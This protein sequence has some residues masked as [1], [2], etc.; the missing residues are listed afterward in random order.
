MMITSCPH[1]PS[2]EQ[3]MTGKK[4]V[5]IPA[6]STAEM[7]AAGGDVINDYDLAI[8]RNDVNHR[9]DVCAD[10]IYKTM[11]TACPNSGKVS[12]EQLM[13]AAKAYMTAQYKHSQYDGIIAAL[14]A[15]GLQIEDQSH[16]RMK[17]D[18]ENE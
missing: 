15:I 6:E 17:K 7:C 14:E 12:R 5:I 16:D 4:M 8:D 11:T 1:G 2:G 10:H 3:V 9:P 13:D 18:K